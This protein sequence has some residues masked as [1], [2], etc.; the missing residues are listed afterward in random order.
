MLFFSHGRNLVGY[1][2]GHFNKVKKL[3]LRG[4]GKSKGT[5]DFLPILNMSCLPTIF[6]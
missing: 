3:N 2:H 4:L 6:L 5:S 1:V